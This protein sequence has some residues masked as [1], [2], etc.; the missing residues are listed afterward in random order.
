[1]QIEFSPDAEKQALSSLRRYCSEELEVD[2][3]ELQARQLLKFVLREIAPTAYNAGVAAAEAFLRDRVADLEGVCH[4][5]EFTYWPKG[6]SV[7]RK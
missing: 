6:T 5:P 4:V 3:S 7:R 2:V 1:M